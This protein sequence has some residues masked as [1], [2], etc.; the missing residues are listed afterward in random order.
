MIME[1]LISLSEFV[2]RAMN[3]PFKPKG[4]D[5]DG[6]DCWGMFRCAYRDV[7][8]I[9][10]PSFA[11]E[12][13]STRPSKDLSELVASGRDRID[14]WTRLAPGDALNVMDGIILRYLGLPVHIGLVISKH[15][16]LHTEAGINTIVEDIRRLPSD[17]SIEGVYR[18]ASY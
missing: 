6:W 1:D 11:E 5:Y 2:D 7:R 8:G 10:L 14:Q 4:R 18:Y 13:T 16:F 3:V 15:K 9:L 17:H 12:Y